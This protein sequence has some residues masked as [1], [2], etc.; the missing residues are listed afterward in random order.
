[1][2]EKQKTV[3]FFNAERKSRIIVSILA[4]LALSLVIFVVAPLDT[5]ASNMEELN[6]S[7]SDFIWMSIL[8]A[9]VAAVIV[10][11]VLFVLPRKVYRILFAIILASAFLITLQ[12]NFLNFGVS[13]LP[14]DNLASDGPSVV[15]VIL[16]AIIWIVGYGAAIFFAVKKNNGSAVKTVALV[17]S[18]M[19]FAMQI[20]SPVQVILTNKNLFDDKIKRYGGDYETATVKNYTAVSES[21]NIYYFC[22]D[23]FDENYAEEAYENDK[24]VFTELDGFTWF[25][26]NISVYGHTYPAVA[27]M[28]TNKEYDGKLTRKEYLDSAYEGDTP[29]KR[30]HDLGYSINLY[31]QDFYAYDTANNLPD[32]VENVLKATDKKNTNPFFMSMVFA[33]ISLYKGAPLVAKNWY[34]QGSTGTLN[35]FV[36]YYGGPY[37]GYNTDTKFAYRETEETSFTLKDNDKSF[38][39]I[40]FEGCHDTKYTE[41]WNDAIFES[42]TTSVKNSMKIVKRFIAELKEKGLYENATII[43]TGDHSDPVNNNRDVRESRRTALFV[44]PSGVSEGFKISSAPVSHRDIWATIFKSEGLDYS[45]YGQS[46]FDVSETETRVRTFIWHTYDATCDE[47]FYEIIGGAGSARDFADWKEVKINHY[48]KHVMK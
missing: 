25:D 35:S 38:N 4:S 11:A 33:F 24:T 30:L 32:Y 27:N 13:S 48:D 37:E 1:M 19:V 41:N 26:D 10:F 44:K 3:A 20:T 18:V 9:F 40:H 28:L 16:D 14:G 43:V 46:V 34:F 21:R 47:Y 5:F 6:F 31:T 15:L 39:F 17:L 2:Q 45:D 42:V 7:I 29:L 36:K 8:V 23:R 22:V 12:Q